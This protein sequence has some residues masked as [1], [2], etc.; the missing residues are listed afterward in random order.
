MTERERLIDILSEIDY[1]FADGSGRA[2][3]TME[4][5]ADY[6]LANGVILSPVKVGDNV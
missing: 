1:I 6:L 2:I 3:D 5:V 4:F